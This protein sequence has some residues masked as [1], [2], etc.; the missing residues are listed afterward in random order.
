MSQFSTTRTNIGDLNIDAGVVIDLTAA[1]TGVFS[2][3]RTDGSE[4]I[5]DEQGFAANQSLPRFAGG[6]SRNMLIETVINGNIPS[7]WFKQLKKYEWA[8]EVGEF[9]LAVAANGSLEWSDATDVIMTAPA[10]S[11]PIADWISCSTAATSGGIGNSEITVDL[12]SATGL[13]TLSF[14]AYTVPDIFIVDYNGVEVINT[15]YR[16]TSGTYDG[17]PVTVAGPPSGT[18]SFTKTTAS[19]SLCTVRVEAPFTGTQWYFNLGCPA[20]GA[21]PYVVPGY[22]RSTFTATSTAYGNTLSGGTPFTLSV[23]YEGGYGFTSLQLT[24]DPLAP[25]L[26]TDFVEDN[27]TR[28]TDFAF[29]IEIDSTGEATIYDQTNIIAIRPTV[30]GAEQYLD[31]SGSYAATTYGKNTY[32]NGVEFFASVSM[33][34]TPPIEL[35]TY[36]KAAVTAGS[37]T[38][39]TGP[40]SAPTLPANSAGVKIIPISY[41]DGLGKLTQFSEGAILWK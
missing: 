10:G 32:N 8:S 7:G 21:P 13:V 23:I 39:V 18:A 4:S 25:Y 19:P 38:G 22:V 20:A 17:V 1:T 14:D 6:S 15:G 27:V 12:G 5:P 29:N 37:I 3:A 33:I 35:Y 24:C 28:W 34:N 11:I 31:P 26:S 40:F 2:I 9:T 16:G 41:S 36:F 30:V